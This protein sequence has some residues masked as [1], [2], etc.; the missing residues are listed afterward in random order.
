MIIMTSRAP[1]GPGA[2]GQGGGLGRALEQARAAARG[3]G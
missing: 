1:D 2:S 3:P